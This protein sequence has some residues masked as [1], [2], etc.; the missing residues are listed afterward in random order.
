MPA[1]LDELATSG[2]PGA[3]K[4]LVDLANAPT[5]YQGRILEH[6]RERFDRPEADRLSQFPEL[7]R[8]PESDGET[9]AYMRFKRQL[10]GSIDPAFANFFSDRF[11]RTIDAREVRFGGVGVDVDVIP[12]LEAPAYVS[13][14]EA[15]AWI[16]DDD[17]IGGIPVSLAYCTLCGSAVDLS[18]GVLRE[19]SGEVWTLN[20]D[21]LVSKSGATL[22]RV[23][24][25]NAFWFAVS[26]LV[27]DGRLYE[28]R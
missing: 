4:Y 23:N 8:L 6:L 7:A 19:E 17:T 14:A 13:P 16:N 5:P 22:A 15:A 24:G 27:D 25:S 2:H 11:E 21:E 1:K 12:P 20:E 18:A 9:A 3:D 26:N 28:G 10:F